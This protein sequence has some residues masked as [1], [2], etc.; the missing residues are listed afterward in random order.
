[1]SACI[2]VACAY[3][4]TPN[5]VDGMTQ[6]RAVLRRHLC[7]AATFAELTNAALILAPRAL[8]SRAASRSP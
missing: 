7:V 1:M 5:G 2:L 6:L 4:I 3:A 8:A